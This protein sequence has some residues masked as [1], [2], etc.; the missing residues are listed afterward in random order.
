M[1][2]KTNKLKQ[3]KAIQIMGEN[4]GLM[5]IKFGNLVNTNVCTFIGE[6]NCL[7]ILAMN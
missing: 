4:I 7:K 6:L 5:N 2:L 1:V 3:T